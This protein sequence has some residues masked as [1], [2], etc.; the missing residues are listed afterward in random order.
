MA[1][2]RK[3]SVQGTGGKAKP[4]IIASCTVVAVIGAVIGWTA[5]STARNNQIAE[6]KY[7]FN[8][9]YP[10]S[11]N[12]DESF[13]PQADY[14]KD[15][16]SNADEV[17]S[18]TSG[19]S[20]DSDGDGVPDGLEKT[21]GTDPLSPDS[22]DDGILDG[23]EIL[24]GTDPL[25]ASTDGVPDKQRKFSRTV[26]FD[27]GS[28][29]FVGGADIFGASVEK[30]SLFSVSSNAGAFSFPYE[31]YSEKPFDSAK[32]TF[33][34]NSGILRAA[35]VEP[36]NV[37]I[38]K[39]DP[40]KKTYAKYGGA[41]DK[42]ANETHGTITENGVYLIGAEHV[43]KAS[44]SEGDTVINIHML[45]DNSGSM[46][47]ST[48][49]YSSEENDVEFK[50]LLFAANLVTKLG[51]GTNT[52]VSAFT[53]NTSLLCDF[54]ADKAAAI[55]SINQ[56]RDIGAGYD[57]TSVERAIMTALDS[58]PKNPV[59]ERN[60][61][62][63]LTDGI[64]TDSAGYTIDDI[65]DIAQAKNVTIM[66]ISLGDSID[67]ELL[68]KIADRTG[69]MYFPISDANALEGLYS[70]LIATMENDIVDED[71]DGTPESYSLYD[72]GFRKEENGFTFH[73]F[74]SRNSSTMDFGMAMLARDW[75]LHHVSETGGRED[76]ELEYDFGKTSININAPLSKVIL[77]S[78]GASYM[79]P[80]SYLDFESVG[81]TLN[82]LKDAENEAKDMGWVTHNEAVPE[83]K[84][85][86]TSA[87]YLVP[88]Y[89]MGKIRVKYGEDDYNMLRA[90]GWYNTFRDTG[91]SFVL[92][93][94]AG[95]SLLKNK[96]SS[97]EPVLMKMTWEENGGYYSRYVNLIALRRDID[98]PNLFNMKIYDTN[99]ESDDTVTLNRTIKISG[100][101]KFHGDYTYTA[102]WSGRGVLISFCLAEVTQ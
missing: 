38:Y 45:I 14:D 28:V 21:Y 98:N 94:E 92:A 101:G 18:S 56:I 41:Y 40:R 72:T 1:K 35:G 43:S 50:R 95:L 97:G 71:S 69:G 62:V 19:S 73:N 2:S 93:D 89:S 34:C 83:N 65:S 22:D 15:G 64:S 79:T 5:Y 68:Q 61:I 39:F 8:K 99:S 17:L 29:T 4:I 90:I 13:D 91:K 55:S 86:W 27:E 85:G 9:F 76:P 51:S 74:K 87:Q 3:K 102:N 16:L 60:M 96:L 78:M 75:F 33:R 11:F 53:Y 25:S 23:I 81:D 70:T 6:L 46:Y 12:T 80:D 59:N 49:K 7:E 84:G 54:T 36:E 20:A 30:L 77:T 31:I 24:A 32:I 63:M 26:D 48:Q 100:D 82:V 44:A 47:R 52:A 37:S 57:G 88:N 67:R 58:F 10:N 66:T 42:E